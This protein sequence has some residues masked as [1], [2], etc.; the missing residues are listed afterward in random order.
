MKQQINYEK[1][2]VDTIN[3]YSVQVHYTF[4]SLDADEMQ[5][6]EKWCERKIGPGVV[7]DGLEFK[8]MEDSDE[9][10]MVSDKDTNNN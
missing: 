8:D 9:E 3:G 4:S 2:K 10:E 7:I 6:F 1:M 5:Q